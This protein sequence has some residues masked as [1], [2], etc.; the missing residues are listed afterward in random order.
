MPYC[1]SEAPNGTWESIK[2]SLYFPENAGER[3]RH[4][5][6]S[7]SSWRT[8]GQLPQLIR[9]D[10]RVCY[11]RTEEHEDKY[12]DNSQAE[13]SCPPNSRV[14]NSNHNQDHETAIPQTLQQQRGYLAQMA[15][16]RWTQRPSNHV[17]RAHRIIP[18]NQTGEAHG[19]GRAI[20]RSQD[21]EA[22]PGWQ[23]CVSAD[24]RLRE[25]GY[26]GVMWARDMRPFEL[27]KR[28]SAPTSSTLQ[29]VLRNTAD[30]GRRGIT[31]TRRWRFAGPRKF[32]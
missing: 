25:R 1:A 14:E 15:A 22:F 11:R 30:A 13:D 21:R 9:G 20:I 3:L 6:G 32:D 31:N 5:L 7:F 12:R 16:S 23:H 24:G 29:V 27:R 4:G 19:Q 18:E 2:T 8:R 28:R 26:L 17:S 10:K